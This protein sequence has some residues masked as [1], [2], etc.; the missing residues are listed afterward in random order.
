METAISADKYMK[1]MEG[2]TNL[3]IHPPYDFAIPNSLITNFHL[4]ESSLLAM[5]AAFAGVDQTLAAYQF[6]IDN[7]FRFYSYGDAMLIT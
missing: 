3:F 1:P 6:A 7:E 2:W 5:V 4:P